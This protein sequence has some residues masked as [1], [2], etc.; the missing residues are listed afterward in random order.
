MRAYL[1]SLHRRNQYHGV[2]AVVC[3]SGVWTIPFRAVVR[4]RANLEQLVQLPF[5]LYRRTRFNQDK[6]LENQRKLTLFYNI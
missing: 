3:K 2:L 4:A 6:T 1:L 5:A